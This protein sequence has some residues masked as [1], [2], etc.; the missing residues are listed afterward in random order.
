MKKTIVYDLP[1]RIFHWLFATLFLIAFTAANLSDDESLI[2]SIHMIAGI[3]LLFVLSLRIFWGLFGTKYARFNSFKLK[4]T[5]L[6]A[7]F[8]QAMA[9]KTKAYF[10]HNPASSYAAVFMFALTIGL[11]ITG[12]SMALGNDPKFFEDAHE[13]MSNLFIITVVAHLLGILFHHLRH[14][15]S[16]WSSMIDG[17]KNS[18]LGETGIKTTRP[19]IGVLFL[20][21]S[22]TWM[23]YVYSNFDQKTRTLTLFGNQLQ[24]GENEGSDN[25]SGTI[26]KRDN[27]K[28]D[29]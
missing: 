4:P 3:S 1:T 17:K 21:L 5:E 14:K 23:G 28:H 9:S 12:I 2:F 7:Y 29:D 10:S 25:H 18:I 11:G 13:I 15:D 16:T 19:I 22:I 26:K 6:I 27:H 24:L 8:K 20:V